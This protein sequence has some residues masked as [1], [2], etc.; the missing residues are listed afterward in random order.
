MIYNGTVL[1]ESLHDESVLNFVTE[2][3]RLKKPLTN[4]STSQP[5]EV[6]IVSFTVADDMAP[7]V[8]DELSRLLKPGHWYADFGN[9][10]DKYVIF[11]GKIFHFAPKETDKKQKAQEYG[12]SLGIPES[13]LDWS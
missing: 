2:T 10:Y 1:L 7:A 5:A 8:A 12:R 4:H 11:P 6:H 13:Q 3:G 9:E